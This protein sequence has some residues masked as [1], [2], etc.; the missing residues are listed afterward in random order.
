MSIFGC[1]IL[2]MWPN[3]VCM[4]NVGETLRARKSI[5]ISGCNVHK[6]GVWDSQMC[7]VY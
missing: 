1:K 7:P 6:Q 2:N 3:T 4:Y 5:D